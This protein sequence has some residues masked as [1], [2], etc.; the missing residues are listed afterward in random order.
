MEHPRASARAVLC[1]LLAACG[2]PWP[3]SGAELRDE[4]EALA[5]D[6]GFALVGIE[7]IGED[8]PAGQVTGSVRERLGALLERYD[9]VVEGTEDSVRRVIVLGRKRAAPPALVVRTR[10]V[11]THHAVDAD[12]RGPNGRRVGVALIVDSGASSIVLPDSMMEPL[13]FDPDALERR[14]TQTAN[15]P[16]EGRA[17]RLSQV[18]VGGAAAREVDVL[19]IP[20]ARLGGISLLGMSFLRDFSFTLD[21]AGGRLI[22]APR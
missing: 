8:E 20:D 15:G 10:R 4:L 3:A 2:A 11:G 7:R 16:V 1:L 6:H 9:H 18:Q 21:D 5:A 19:F 12:L 17:G 22:L 14:R 13:G